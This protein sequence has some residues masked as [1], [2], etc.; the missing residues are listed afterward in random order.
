ML[1]AMND[2]GTYAGQ[3]K[4]RGLI[5]H[6]VRFDADAL[7]S[8]TTKERPVIAHKAPT[9]VLKAAALFWR[10]CR[11]GRISLPK[12]LVASFYLHHDDR[13]VFIC[14]AIGLKSRVTPITFEHHEPT[15]RKMPRRDS[16]APCT[17]RTAPC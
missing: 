16:L 17:N 15:R 12:G 7:D 13:P 5:V 4:R 8:K 11:L 3:A 14:D 9:Q 2:D 6:F 10:H 1:G